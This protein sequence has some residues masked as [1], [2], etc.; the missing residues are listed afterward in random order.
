MA[1]FVLLSREYDRFPYVRRLRSKAIL[2]TLEPSP[3]PLQRP[4]PLR[5]LSLAS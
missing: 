4:P 1:E 5:T 2:V 3:P